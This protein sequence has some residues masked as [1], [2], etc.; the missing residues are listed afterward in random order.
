MCGVALSTNSGA[1]SLGFGSCLELSGC[2]IR[3]K[4]DSFKNGN[5]VFEVHCED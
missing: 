2:A 5:L 4:V 1:N 3:R